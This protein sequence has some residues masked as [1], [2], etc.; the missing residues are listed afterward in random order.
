MLQ[1]IIDDNLTLIRLFRRAVDRE[2][3]LDFKNNQILNSAGLPN[4]FLT[5]EFMRA[6]KTYKENPILSAMVNLFYYATHWGTAIKVAS[7]TYHKF[8]S[9]TNRL[10]L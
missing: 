5:N 1:E 4:N 10:C 6:A 8:K 3:D 2:I 9:P 7:Y